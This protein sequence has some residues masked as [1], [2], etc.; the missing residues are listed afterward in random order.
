MSG[1]KNAGY[2]ALGAMAVAIAKPVGVMVSGVAGRL[3]YRLM[4]GITEIVKQ[5]IADILTE[6]MNERFDREQDIPVLDDP[7]MESV[8]DGRNIPEMTTGFIQ[9]Q[10]DQ[11]DQTPVIVLDDYGL[12]SDVEKALIEQFRNWMTDN[13]N[14]TPIMIS[15]R[16]GHVSHNN[17]Q[18]FSIEIDGQVFETTGNRSNPID[19]MLQ[20]GLHRLWNAIT[21]KPNGGN[22]MPGQFG[23]FDT[24]ID[25]FL[26]VGG[27]APDAMKVTMYPAYKSEGINEKHYDISFGPDRIS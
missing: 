23:N 12:P 16:M 26:S 15:M 13:S 5:D 19:D 17:E 25:M 3:R 9:E 6:R 21:A 10:D 18:I 7:D 20:T 8:I 11:E 27:L 2:F 14:R 24:H 22:R 1:M 4:S